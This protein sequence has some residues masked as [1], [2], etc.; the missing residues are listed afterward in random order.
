MIRFDTDPSRYLH[1]RL[2]CDGPIATLTLDVAEAGGLSPGYPLKLNSYDLG[3]S[4][5]WWSY[6]P[7]TQTKLAASVGSPAPLY[8]ASSG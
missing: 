8:C 2:A 5:Q 3:L 1:R 4:A 7:P 6:R